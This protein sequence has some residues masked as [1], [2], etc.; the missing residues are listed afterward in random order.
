MIFEESVDEGSKTL[1]V[2]YRFRKKDLR[3]I[4]GPSQLAQDL[5][6]TISGKD[7]RNC[8]PIPPFDVVPVYGEG[9]LVDNGDIPGIESVPLVVA[10]P[11]N[12]AAQLVALSHSV[13]VAGPASTSQNDTYL[14]PL[15]QDQECMSCLLKR[16]AQGPRTMRTR[17]LCM[18]T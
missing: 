10:L 4:L 17:L 2:A 9:L 8:G 1:N 6:T 7:C 13:A 18:L 12:T 11:N 16:A 3:F 15:L 5:C 14:T